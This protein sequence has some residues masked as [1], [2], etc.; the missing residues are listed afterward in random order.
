MLYFYRM[1]SLDLCYHVDLCYLFPFNIISIF[2]TR[3]TLVTFSSHS[4]I[5]TMKRCVFSQMNPMG[6]MG[7]MGPMGQ[8]GGVQMG[9]NQMG[10]AQMGGGQMGGAQMGGGQ[11]G[12]GQ[13]S[14]GQMGGM[15]GQMFGGQYGGMQ[16]GYGYG[17]PMIQGGQQQMINQVL[18]V[19]LR[20]TY[21]RVS[22]KVRYLRR[23]QF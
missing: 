23:P 17:Q 18:Q 8:M 11:M 4:I 12:G 15:S 20:R 19:E 2:V 9:P 1:F 5:V 6:G 10:A 13:M 16:Q 14:G 22:T 21:F 7:G 3:C